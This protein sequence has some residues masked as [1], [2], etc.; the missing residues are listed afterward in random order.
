[1][2]SKCLFNCTTNLVGGGVKNSALFIKFAIQDHNFIWYFAIS[3]QVKAILEEWGI[4]CS[5]MYV[6]IHSPSK[7]KSSR[8]KLGQLAL[9][10]N[11]DLVYTMAGP[12]YVDFPCTHVLGMSE[13]YVSHANWSEVRR[14]RSLLNSIKTLGLSLYKSFYAKKADFWIFQTDYSKNC[15]SKRLSILPERTVTIFNAIDLNIVEYFKEKP[16]RK[17]GTDN[18]IIVLCP[19]GPYA[20]KALDTIPYLANLMKEKDIPVRFLLTVDTDTDCWKL[21]T[22][23]ARTL[24]VSDNIE[25]LG[26]YNYATVNNVLSK[27]DIVYVPSILETFSASYIEAF[28]AKVPL[29]CADKGFARDVCGNAA[30]YVDPLDYETTTNH[31]IELISS[32]EK[33]VKIISDGVKMLSLYGD[34]KLRFERVLNYLNYILKLD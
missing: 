32:E 10:L 27:A 1:M 11:A 2:V 31:F 16:F 30:I 25:T 19:G 7:N 34:Q 9:E 17:L 20:H 24:N 28:A 26:S 15:F 21:I 4:D 14:G 22:K 8:V 12:A 33:Q 23:L 3:P 6:F 18:E 5:K 13:P 29:V